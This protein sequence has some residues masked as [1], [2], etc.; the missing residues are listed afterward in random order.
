MN[1]DSS[2][3]VFLQNKLSRSRSKLD[4]LMPVLD[5]KRKYARSFD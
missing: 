5:A 3:K 1:I 2:P 4:E